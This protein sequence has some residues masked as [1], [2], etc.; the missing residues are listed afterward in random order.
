MNWRVIL[1]ICAILTPFALG[2]GA[3]SAHAE[4]DRVTPVVEAVRRVGP[5]VVHISTEQLRDDL[6]F[7]PNPII[8]RYYREFFERHGPVQPE[9]RALGSGVIID[10]DG[11]VLTNEHVIMRTGPIKVTLSDGRTFTA[12]VVGSEPARDLAVLKIDGDQPFPTAPLGD[13]SDLLIGET[14]IAIGSPFGLSNTVTTGVVSATGRTIRSDNERVYLDFIQTDASINPGNSGGPLLNINGEVIGI[15]TA[16]YGDAQGIGFAIPANSAKAIVEDLIQFGQVNYGWFGIRVQSL[17]PAIRNTLGYTGKGGLYASVVFAESPAAK[18]GLKPG[19]VIEKVGPYKVDAPDTYRSAVRGYT[20]GS[21]VDITFFRDGATRSVNITTTGFPEA[22][23]AK[24]SWILLGW[25]VAPLTKSQSAK[26]GLPAGFGM[27]ITEVQP[28]SVAAKF[29]I[30]AGDV[31]LEI[32][33]NEIANES[34]YNVAVA[35]LRLKSSAV[36]LLQRGGYRSY[37]SLPLP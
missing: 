23:V 18:A 25:K 21:T 22:M 1:I 30:Q 8:D 24:Y 17:T 3:R 36:V 37:V 28:D 29:G 7:S 15:N 12:K 32:N 2:G 14:V 4:A 16:I 11:Y 35:G 33:T 31:V 10:K 9:A 19:D 5:A 6:R 26:L 13:S 34:A 20:V 27:R